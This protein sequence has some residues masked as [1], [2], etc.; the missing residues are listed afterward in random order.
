MNAALLLYVGY[1]K[2][3][4]AIIALRRRKGQACEDP[5]ADPT[6]RADR[7]TGSRR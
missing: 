3:T 2:A 5:P 7:A 1:V 4:Q 6:P